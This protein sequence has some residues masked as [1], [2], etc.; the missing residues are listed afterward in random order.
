MVYWN[1]S[2]NCKTRGF[3]KKKYPHSIINC[4]NTKEYSNCFATKWYSKSN[5]TLLSFFYFISYTSNM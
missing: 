2:H 3:D 4:F 1:L 5:L